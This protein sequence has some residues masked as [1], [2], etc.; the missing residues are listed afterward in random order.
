MP[1]R[2]KEVAAW[3]DASD[4]KYIDGIRRAVARYERW[5]F[6]NLLFCGVFGTVLFGLLV[7]VIQPLMNMPGWGLGFVIGLAT[8]LILGMLA[9]KI[10]QILVVTLID[11]DRSNRLL[12]R[13]HDALKEL[14]QDS[15]AEASAR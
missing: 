15:G 3:F 9:G 8:G 12:L 14:S 10:A 5:R 11:D 1:D 13:Y 4:E 6:W 2:F 7:W